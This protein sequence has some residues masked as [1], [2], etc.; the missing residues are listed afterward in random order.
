MVYLGDINRRDLRLFQKKAF[1]DASLSARSAN[2]SLANPFYST[3]KS[4]TD[5]AQYLTKF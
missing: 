2:L 3:G 5:A 1:I 4:G